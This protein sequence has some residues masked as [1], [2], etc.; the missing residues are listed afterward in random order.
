MEELRVYAEGTRFLKMQEVESKLSFVNRI[1]F[2]IEPNGVGYN[3]RAVLSPSRELITFSFFF[4]KIYGF[5]FDKCGDLKR[6]SPSAGALYPIELYLVHFEAGHWKLL[7]YNFKVH[8]FNEIEGFNANAFVEEW[9]PETGRSY[10]LFYSVFW[11]SA[12]RYGVRSLRYAYLDAACILYNAL[13]AGATCGQKSFSLKFSTCCSDRY[14]E[15]RDEQNLLFSLEVC[16][17]PPDMNISQNQHCWD[18]IVRPVNPSSVY[19]PTVNNAQ[20]MRVN[21]MIDKGKQSKNV[22]CIIYSDKRAA[23][24]GFEY[25]LYNRTSAKSFKD[26][27]F[28]LSAF[29]NIKEDLINFANCIDN[30]ASGL[31]FELILIPLN[32]SGIA[33]HIW[34]VLQDIKKDMDSRRYP[35]FREQIKACCQQQGLLLN[36]GLVGIVAVKLDEDVCLSDFQMNYSRSIVMGG[37]FCGR[38]YQSSV[39]NNVGTSTIGGFSEAMVV[40]FAMLGDYFPIVLQAFGIEDD[41]FIKNDAWGLVSID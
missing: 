3:G 1:N 24:A 20:L 5:R 13:L 33:P 11:R 34:F 28:P 36:S 12:Q 15:G 27:P 21:A 6:M 38:A 9:T 39:H 17:L 35:R 2:Q 10:I 25:Y 29:Q 41:K 31:A 23:E 22:D 19:S 40:D 14:S 37:L 30:L 7:H 26:V 16:D 4:E 32:V 18:E 8:R